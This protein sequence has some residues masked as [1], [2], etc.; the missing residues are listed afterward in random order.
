MRRAK[1]A[2]WAGAAAATSALLLGGLGA[3]V[4]AFWRSDAEVPEAAFAVGQVYAAVTRGG[5]VSVASAASQATLT[6]TSD[7]AVATVTPPSGVAIPFEIAVKGAGHTGVDYSFVLPTA[8]ELSVAGSALFHFYPNP[9]TC[10]VG[11]VPDD[12]WTASSGQ[13]VGPF[14]GMAPD[15]GATQPAL[16]AWCLVV[17][18]D[19]AKALSVKNEATA[20][21]T[22]DG[23]LVEASDSWWAN[24]VL[25]DPGGNADYGIALELVFTRPNAGSQP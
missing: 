10:E 9:G 19:P 17:E 8:A 13:K 15:A 11:S 12:A 4:G 2:L 5:D 22:G 7:D 21:A 20:Q 23:K 18:P 25:P 24:V 6:F 3:G 1:W 16:A 14:T